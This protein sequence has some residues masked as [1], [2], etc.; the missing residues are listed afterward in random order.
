MGEWLKI[1]HMVKKFLNGLAVKNV[2]STSIE[3]ATQNYNQNE[4]ERVS[5]V[6]ELNKVERTFFEDKNGH[7]IYHELCISCSKE[8][9]QSHKVNDVICNVRMAAH[10]PDEY[11]EKIKKAKKDINKIGKELGLKNA[12]VRDML[13][14]R[15]DMTK[16]L[17][18]KLEKMFYPKNKK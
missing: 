8:C 10:A 1:P 12:M 11:I 13:L 3:N 18:E 7:V 15:I 17:Y 9:K 5:G 14:E 2:S 16:E 4:G 6:R